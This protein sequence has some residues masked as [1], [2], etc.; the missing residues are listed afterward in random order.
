[1]SALPSREPDPGEEPR[2]SRPPHEAVPLA[3]V[4]GTLGFELQPRLDPPRPRGDEPADDIEDGDLPPPIPIVP[5]N[6]HLRGWVPQFAQK[7][8]EV[9]GGDRPAS[10]LVRWTT[11]EVY[12]ELRYRASLTARSGAY[13]PGT[14]RNQPVRPRVHRCHV[15]EVSDDIVEATVTIRFGAGLRALAVRFERNGE[16]WICTVL[17]FGGYD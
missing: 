4:Q 7:A 15:Y 17:N 1:M 14:G 8:A 10:Q 2:P 9:V 11:K 16:S 3:D 13:E 12:A 6:G 5:A